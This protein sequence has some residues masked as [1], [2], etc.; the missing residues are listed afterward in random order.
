MCHASNYGHLL[1][2]NASVTIPV[3]EATDDNKKFVQLLLIDFSK[4]FDHIIFETSILR[5]LLA[6]PS[7]LPVVYYIKIVQEEQN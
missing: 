1:L 6:I 7:P 4:A 2:Y 3:Y 5:V